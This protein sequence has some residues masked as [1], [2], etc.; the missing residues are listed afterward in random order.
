MFGGGRG[1]R[2]LYTELSLQRPRF[3][4][5][6]RDESASLAGSL[7]IEIH[8]DGGRDTTLTVF[9]AGRLFPGWAP[10]SRDQRGIYFG[11]VGGGPTWMEPTDSL[12]VSLEVTEALEGR[13]PSEGSIPEGPLPRHGIVWSSDRA[14]RFRP[15]WAEPPAHRVC[16]LLAVQMGLDVTEERG[17]TGPVAEEHRGV[18][19]GRW[20][21][22]GERL[23]G[24]RGTDGF[25]CVH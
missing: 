5:F 22:L 10:I 4:W 21:E 15:A 1:E 9:E 25:R 19:R 20:G 11:F 17:W 7:H 23:F 12:V 18:G 2:E 24:A 8:R 6:F 3:H 13:F 16:E 14:S